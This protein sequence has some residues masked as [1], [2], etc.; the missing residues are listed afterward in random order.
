MD[1]KKNIWFYVAILLANNVI[2]VPMSRSSCLHFF[3]TGINK[4]IAVD[5]AYFPVVT[6]N[7]P[8]AVGLLQDPHGNTMLSC[9][10]SGFLCPLSDAASH[11]EAALPEPGSHHYH[12]T[13]VTTQ[14]GLHRRSNKAS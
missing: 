7:D 9:L 4:Q 1:V 3:F 10:S 13:T 12:A 14:F 8:R 6:S 5:A 2:Q 11:S